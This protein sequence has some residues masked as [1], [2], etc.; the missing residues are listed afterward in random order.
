MQTIPFAI[1]LSGIIKIGAG[2]VTIAIGKAQTTVDLV[3]SPRSD[4]RLFLRKGQTLFDIILDTAREFVASE[5]QQAQFSA[6]QLYYLAL[7]EYPNLK[8]NSWTAHVMASAPNHPSHR[9]FSVRKDY[10][11]YLGRAT[12]RLRPKYLPANTESDHDR[13]DNN[14]NK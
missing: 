4:A 8:R 10:F 7:D 9:H 11:E 5:G 13:E 12:Y 3:P 6:A 1:S 14:V 2:K